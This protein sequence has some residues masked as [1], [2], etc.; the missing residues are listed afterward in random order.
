MTPYYVLGELPNCRDGE[1]TSEM[2]LRFRYRIQI[3]EG[4]YLLDT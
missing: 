4:L 1:D 2:Y 3:H